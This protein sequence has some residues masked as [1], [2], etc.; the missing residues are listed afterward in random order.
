MY[1]STMISVLTSV[2]FGVSA[3]HIRTTKP[4]CAESSNYLLRRSAESSKLSTNRQ[5]VEIFTTS[6]RRSAESSKLSNA[7]N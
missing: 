7:S 2:V 6:M 1:L 5:N 3:E 4:Y